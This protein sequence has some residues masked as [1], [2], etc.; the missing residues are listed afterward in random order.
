MNTVHV[1]VL[2]VVKNSFFWFWK[3]LTSW[4]KSKK[5]GSY[6][7]KLCEGREAILKRARELDVELEKRKDARRI[8]RVIAAPLM[9]GNQQYFISNQYNMPR[10]PLLLS[11]T[12]SPNNIPDQLPADLGA[13]F[14]YFG[15][16]FEN[17]CIHAIFS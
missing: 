2:I 12:A 11:T 1:R 16:V 6:H 8:H 9:V 4:K 10:Q 3:M 5:S 15:A 17:M 7:R 13:F 14:T